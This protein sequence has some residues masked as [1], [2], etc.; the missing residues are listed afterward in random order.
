MKSNKNLSNAPATPLLL[1][2]IAATA[3]YLLSL[4]AAIVQVSYEIYLRGPFTAAVC[5][6]TLTLLQTIYQ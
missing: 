5:T 2:I 1:I 3:T 6:L 4:R